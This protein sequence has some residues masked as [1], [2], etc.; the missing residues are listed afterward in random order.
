MSKI[1][2]LIEKFKSNPTDLTWEEL[3]KILKYLGYDELKKKGK[4]GGSRRKFVNSNKEIINLHKPHP[5][6]IV[7]NYVI[8]Q[9]L[10]YL[11]L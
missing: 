11:K 7:K 3:V 2:K 6:N 10:E 1:A 5:G 8:K 4:T 9:L